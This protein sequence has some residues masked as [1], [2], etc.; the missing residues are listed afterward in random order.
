M[1]NTQSLISNTPLRLYLHTRHLRFQAR[2]WLH[3]NDPD[4][5]A[6]HCMFHLN[7]YARTDRDTQP[8]YRL[9]D[10]LVRIFYQAGLYRS[11]RLHRQT[12]ECWACRGTGVS[13]DWDGYEEPCYKCGGTGIYREHMLYSF[14]FSIAGQHY[15][16]HQPQRLVTWPVKPDF[17]PIAE[18]QS[19]RDRYTVTL[20]PKPLLQ[21]Y[22]VTVAEYLVLHGVPRRDLPAFGPRSLRRALVST[23]HLSRLCNRCFRFRRKAKQ[24]WTSIVLAA[25]N[26]R[27]LWAYIETGELPRPKAKQPPPVFD[28]DLPF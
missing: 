27:R 1:T 15:A 22:A 20:L 4:A 17:A 10:H 11:V 9:K 21:L 6:A 7:R 26:L 2:A 24:V 5:V 14:H 8:I 3:N 19:P 25:H 12:L 16:W 13:N 28:D 23:W 18:Y